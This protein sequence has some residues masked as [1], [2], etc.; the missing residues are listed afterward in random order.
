VTLPIRV[1]RAIGA[2]TLIVTNAAGA[3]NRDFS[4]G[5]LMLIEDHLNLQGSNPLIGPN[6]K[7]YGPRFPDMST[8]YTP[9][10]RSVAREAAAE[11]GV[12]LK[13]GVYACLS[14]PSYETPAEIRMLRTLG[15]DAVGM[16]TVPEVIVAAHAGMRVLGISCLT[17]MAAGVLD[18]P[19]DHAEVIE[20]SRRVRGDF[21]RLMEAIIRR[22]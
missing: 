14:G 4:A 10:L 1:M 9:A 17:N 15:A 16:S 18:Q 22:C 11:Q 13:S 5:D 3:V 8:A 12:A 6:L 21:I 2:E 19:L 7:V 20:T